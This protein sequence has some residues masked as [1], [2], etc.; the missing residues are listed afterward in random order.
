MIYKKKNDE[1]QSKLKKVRENDTIF[2]LI[3]QM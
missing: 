2:V 3:I 1:A